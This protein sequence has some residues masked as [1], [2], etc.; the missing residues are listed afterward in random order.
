MRFQT[1]WQP[2]RVC[3]EKRGRFLVHTRGQSRWL[4]SAAAEAAGGCD[5]SELALLLSFAV[6]IM[7]AR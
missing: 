3:C 7:G 5:D 4:H 6:P 2:L 1:E